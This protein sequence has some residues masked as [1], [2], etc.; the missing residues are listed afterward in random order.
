MPAVV[1]ALAAFIALALPEIRKAVRVIPFGKIELVGPSV[2]VHRVTTHVHHGIDR[3]RAAQN[4]A[5]WDAELTSAHG[6]LFFREVVPVESRVTVDALD[7]RWDVYQQP[8]VRPTCFDQQD[9][10][11]TVLRESVCQHAAC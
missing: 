11:L 6:A 3:R 10:R 7:S 9:R 5:T 8:I 2:V 1:F 4:L